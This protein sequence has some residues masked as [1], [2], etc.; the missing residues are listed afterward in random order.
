MTK[1]SLKESLELLDDVSR[2][3]NEFK[4]V[5]RA[6]EIKNQLYDKLGFKRK[7]GD[8]VKTSHEVH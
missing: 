5:K 2:G 8:N 6:G 7:S 3:N 4:H 1:I